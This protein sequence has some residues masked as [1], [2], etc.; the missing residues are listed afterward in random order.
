METQAEG[1]I[2]GFEVQLGSA[3][4]S[5]LTTLPDKNITDRE[6]VIKKALLYVSVNGSQRAK[7]N[8]TIRQLVAATPVCYGVLRK[9][10]FWRIVLDYLTVE[11]AVQAYLVRFPKTLTDRQRQSII[12][13]LVDERKF[14][15]ELVNQCMVKFGRRRRIGYKHS[16]TRKSHHGFVSN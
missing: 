3:V 8:K 4:C 13:Y 1:D 14:S 15:F 10:T 9:N 16:C 7:A 6:L 2:V 5:V 12:D 11:E